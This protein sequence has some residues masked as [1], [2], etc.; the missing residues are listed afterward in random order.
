MQ[1]SNAHMTA[2][3]AVFIGTYFGELR[4]TDELVNHGITIEGAVGI[5]AI[6]VAAAGSVA[7]KVMRLLDGGDSAEL[8]D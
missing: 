2:G 4:L 7:V 6:A 5:A 1:A 8:D 3:A